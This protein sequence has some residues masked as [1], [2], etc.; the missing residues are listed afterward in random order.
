M[1]ETTLQINGMMS[2]F[3]DAGVE[4]QIQRTA[5]VWRV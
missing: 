1:N 4:N 5:T 3:D 2:M